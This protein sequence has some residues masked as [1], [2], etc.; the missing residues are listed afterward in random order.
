MKGIVAYDRQE[1]DRRW[2][3]GE[4]VHVWKPSRKSRVELGNPKVVTGVRS[5]EKAWVRSCSAL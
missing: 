2:L 3:Q 4:G 1:S 5:D